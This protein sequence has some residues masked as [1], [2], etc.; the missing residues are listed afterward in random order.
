MSHAGRTREPTTE[1]LR[2][3]EG[4]VVGGPQAP[5]EWYT[6]AVERARSAPSEAV[7]PDEPTPAHHSVKAQEQDALFA[8]QSTVRGGA[9][10]ALDT[11]RAIV[12]LYQY[13]TEQATDSPMLEAYLHEQLGNLNT[14]SKARVQRYMQRDARPQQVRQVDVTMQERRY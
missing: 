2:Q 6:T 10:L 1:E 9:V 5:F 8:A 3:I 7:H 12:D 11:M 14:E 4:E 13:A